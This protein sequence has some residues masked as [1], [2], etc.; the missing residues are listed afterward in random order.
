[1]AEGGNLV[2]L[3]SPH[4]G[5]TPEG[6]FGKFSRKGQDRNDNAC[7]AAVAAYTWLV[8]NENDWVITQGKSARV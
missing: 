2:V 6:E 5:C 1:M 7:G 4:V 8:N 3:F